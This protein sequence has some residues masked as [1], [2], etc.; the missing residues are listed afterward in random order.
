MKQTLK[1]LAAL[2]CYAALLA[3][4][5]L[6]VIMFMCLADAEGIQL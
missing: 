4:F 2:T 6:A 5:W 1:H 3:I